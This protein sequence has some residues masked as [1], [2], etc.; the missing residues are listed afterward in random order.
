MKNKKTLVIAIVAVVLVVA[1]VLGVVLLGGNNTDGST[2]TTTNPAGGTGTGTEKEYKL[3]MGVAF[4]EHTNEQLNATVATVVLD[5]QGKIVACRI[6]AVQNKYKLDLDNATFNFTVLETKMELGSRYGMAG[7]VDNNKDGVMLEWDAQTKAFENYVVGKTVAQIKAMTT[8]EVNGHHISTDNALLSAGCT[9]QIGDFI[10]AVVKACEDTQGV[11]F[12]TSKA[13]TL[14]VSA[15]SADNGTAFDDDN[16]VTIAMN[17]DFGAAVV[18]DGKIIAALNDAYQPSVLVDYEN[19]VQKTGDQRTKR[20]KK[21]DYGMAGK[22]DNDDNGVML[23]WFEQ[24][25]AFSKHVV[26]MTGAQVKA[27]ETTP[28]KGHDITTDKDLLAAGCSMQIT[29]L[30]AVVGEA[31]DNA[32]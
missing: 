8:Q 11:T 15:N 19:V 4:G 25:L 28:A 24:S 31:V 20:E 21:G 9:I 10:N 32:R 29:G 6:D 13:F 23:E 17:V 3:G 16:G 12:K 18:A 2:T 1:V 7:K 5:A 30:M 27:M 22:V 26:G 14:G